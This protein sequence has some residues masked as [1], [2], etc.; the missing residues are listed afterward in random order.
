MDLQKRIRRLEYLIGQ[1]AAASSSSTGVGTMLEI[2]IYAGAAVTTTATTFQEV[3]DRSLALTGPFGSAPVVPAW[4]EGLPQTLGGRN[5]HVQFW[6]DIGWMNNGGGSNGA[7]CRLIDTTHANTLIAG[8]DLTTTTGFN[9]L[10]GGLQIGSSAGQIRNDFAG[11]TVKY[12][13]QFQIKGANAGSADIATLWAAR[14][15]F[16]YA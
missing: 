2:P 3:S 10:F 11:G 9:A 14:F 16:Y 6:A 4:I 12:Q 7:E 5:L 1:Q 15:M 8:S 13:L